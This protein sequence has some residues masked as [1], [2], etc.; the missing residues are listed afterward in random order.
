MVSESVKIRKMKQVYRRC[1]TYS[2][3]IF[4]CCGIVSC[5]R[6]ILGGN[7]DVGSKDSRGETKS[8]SLETSKSRMPLTE[9]ESAQTE[10]LVEM[11]RRTG[12]LEHAREHYGAIFFQDVREPVI[13]ELIN[14][15]GPSLP[16]V[17]FGTES[18]DRDRWV[19][20]DTGRRAM[21]IHLK[22][23][24]SSLDEASFGII[25]QTSTSGGIFCGVQTVKN[26]G[27]W[28]VAKFEVAVAD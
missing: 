9:L 7:G 1:S 20:K 28:Q 14:R 11:L 22:T 17:L 25:A 23:R 12:I 5:T 2:F 18:L 16:R 27:T 3:F 26:G 19:D 24:S 4:L 8:S 10:A 6:G 15:S 21:L 13:K